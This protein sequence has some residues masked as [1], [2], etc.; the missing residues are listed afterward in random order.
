MASLPQYGSPAAAST[1]NE[2]NESP[3]QKGKRKLAEDMEDRGC[4]TALSNVARL[5][6]F[7]SSP[8]NKKSCLSW[9]ISKKCPDDFLQR[10]IECNPSVGLVADSYAKGG[11]NGF[12]K[13]Y[14]DIVRQ[15]ARS[16]RNSYSKSIK[17]TFVDPKSEHNLL[18]GA[19]DNDGSGL[20][21]VSAPTAPHTQHDFAMHPRLRLWRSWTTWTLRNSRTC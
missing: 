11:Y 10:M 1:Q 17:A 9:S 13:K 18:L 12:S 19:T 20:T 7:H 2:P 3:E 5:V 8:P 16:A 6:V 21:Q 4:K 14:A 15:A